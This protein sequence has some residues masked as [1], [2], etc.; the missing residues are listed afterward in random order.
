MTIYMLQ[1]G[2]NYEAPWNWPY[3]NERRAEEEA[4]KLREDE[5]SSYDFVRVVPRTVNTEE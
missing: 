3:L 4:Q 1:Y 5:D 2:Y